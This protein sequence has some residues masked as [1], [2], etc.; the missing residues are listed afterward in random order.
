M[1]SY[2]EEDKEGLGKINWR[3]SKIV[4]LARLGNA[5]DLRRYIQLGERVEWSD[6]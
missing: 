2:K 3:P 4:F 1:V 5:R 6:L